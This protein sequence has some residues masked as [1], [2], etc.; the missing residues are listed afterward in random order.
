MAERLGPDDL[1]LLIEE[2][3]RAQAVPSSQRSQSAETG[4]T[5]MQNERARAEAYLTHPVIIEAITKA[6][7]EVESHA[8]KHFEIIIKGLER[9]SEFR[10]KYFGQKE[11][12]FEKTMT[13]NAAEI[14]QKDQEI[15][16]LRKQ[17]K[18]FQAF[19][20]LTQAAMQSTPITLPSADEFCKDIFRI[21]QNDAAHRADKQ[22]N[23][24]LKKRLK[25]LERKDPT[26]L[27]NLPANLGKLLFSK[28]EA[29]I[30]PMARP[31]TPHTPQLF[32]P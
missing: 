24:K 30:V 4:L 22:E 16:K 21:R 12:H 31:D 20:S 19:S 26:A 32:I 3:D 5:L 2:M 7:L 23:I 11:A 17:I 29:Q 6:R 9:Q 13:T 27:L 28:R 8:Q 10:S 14:R 1:G 15:A 25:V 18:S